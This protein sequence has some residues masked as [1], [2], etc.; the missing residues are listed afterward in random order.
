MAIRRPESR[1]LEVDVVGDGVDRRVTE[2][3][4]TRT[5]KTDFR[6]DATTRDTIPSRHTASLRNMASS[7]PG[8]G[9]GTTGTT[10]ISILRYPGACR[11]ASCVTANWSRARSTYLDDPDTT[12]IRA[13]L[14]RY[15]SDLK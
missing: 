15:S 2:E 9:A 13:S 11:S 10:L 7:P 6:S 12:T 4:A 3:S 5:K 8:A 1:S 14:G